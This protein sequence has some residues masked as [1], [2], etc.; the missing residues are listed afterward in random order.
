LL[1]VLGCGAPCP[2]EECPIGLVRWSCML[3]GAKQYM[4]LTRYIYD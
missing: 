3:C 1:A 4:V 2:A